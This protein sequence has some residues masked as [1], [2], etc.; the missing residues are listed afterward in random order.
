MYEYRGSS[1]PIKLLF[2]SKNALCIAYVYWMGLNIILSLSMNVEVLAWPK[3]G[4]KWPLA[5]S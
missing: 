2:I 3:G 4:L 1:T 5:L